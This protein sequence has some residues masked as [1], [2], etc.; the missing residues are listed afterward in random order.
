MRLSER[1]TSSSGFMGSGDFTAVDC[2]FGKKTATETGR[3]SAATPTL[4]FER[5]N[6][7]KTN[8][9]TP[10]FYRAATGLAVF[11]E[12]FFAAFAALAF[13]TGQSLPD[14]A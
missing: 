9:E 7:S 1:Q 8:D 12:A 13:A 10:P 4:K 14:V 5:F 2:W 3:N 11:F 6:L